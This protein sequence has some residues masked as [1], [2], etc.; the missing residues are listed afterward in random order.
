VPEI[1]IV[2][3]AADLTGAT[4]AYAIG[5]FGMIELVARHGAKVH[6]TPERLARAEHWFA[7]YGATAVPISRV[8]PLVR[9]YTSFPP[10]RRGCHT[11]GSC[12]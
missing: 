9:A 6:I 7:R 12:S 11:R 2:G 10:A 3:V 1:I 8:L 5:Y 4:I